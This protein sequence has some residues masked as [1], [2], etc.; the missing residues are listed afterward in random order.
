VAGFDNGSLN[1]GIFFQAKQFGSILRGSGPPVPQ[2]GVVGDLYLD[3]Q[4]FQL[5]EKRAHD[6]TDPWGHYLFV[7]PLTYQA[8]LKWFTAA[9]PDNSVG[10]TGDYA[11]LWSGFGNYGL[12]P[13]IF[14]PKNAAGWPENGE[15]PATQIDPAFAGFALP[16]GIADEGAPAAFSTSTQLIVEGVLDE[17]ILAVPVNVGASAPVSPVGLQSVPANFTVPLN[18]LYPAIDGHET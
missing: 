15:G 14:G 1:G 4:S 18:L 8:Q 7:L 2:A 16:V 3:V 13:S 17:F 6:S 10:A 12:Q 5:F 11:L 9:A